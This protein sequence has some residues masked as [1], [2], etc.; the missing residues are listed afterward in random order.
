MFVF[1]NCLRMKHS[2]HDIF[3]SL[4]SQTYIKPKK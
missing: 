4:Y 1:P 2:L 3:T